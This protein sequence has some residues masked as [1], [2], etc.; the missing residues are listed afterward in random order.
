MFIN[1]LLNLKSSGESKIWPVLA[2]F[3]LKIR[4]NVNRERREQKEKW[5]D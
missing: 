1:I 5:E 2:V 4:L 3:L